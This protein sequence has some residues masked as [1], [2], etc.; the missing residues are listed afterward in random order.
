MNVR[1]RR[2]G[3]GL[4]VVAALVAAGLWL[5]RDLPRRQVERA[6]A[7]R[8]RGEVRVGRLQVNGLHQA[9][10]EGLKVRGSA[11]LPQL[12]SLTVARVEADGPL[13]EMARGRFERLRLDGLE[14]VLTPDPGRPEL[15]PA[16][17][18]VGLLEVPGASITLR[19]GD[20]TTTLALDAH[21]RDLGGAVSGEVR[22][23]GP[24]LDLA[25]LHA[26]AGAPG[27]LPGGMV[28]AGIDATATLEPGGRARLFAAAEAVTI[29]RGDRQVTLDRPSVEAHT[30]LVDGQVLVTVKPELSALGPTQVE[31]ALAL[32]PLR[33]EHL[34]ARASAIE[35]APWLPALPGGVTIAGIAELSVEGSPS[36]GIRTQVAIPRA[37]VHTPT[38]ALAAAVHLT[39]MFSLDG[40]SLRGPVEATI[41]L[42]SSTIG[43]PA[44]LLPARLTASGDATLGARSRFAGHLE[45]A[46]AAA[47]TTAADGTIDVADQVALDLAWRWQGGDVAKLVELATATG[48]LTLPAGFELDGKLAARGVVSGTL[49]APIIN[50]T[51]AVDQARAGPTDGD[52]GWSAIVLHAVLQLAWDPTTR[53]LE[54]SLPATAAAI[55]L[56]PLEPLE[57]QLSAEGSLDPAARLVRAGRIELEAPG[58][59]RAHATG[60]GGGA[61]PFSAQLHVDVPEVERVRDTLRPLFD[62]VPHDLALAGAAAADLAITLS[63]AE[64][65]TAAGPVTLRQAGFTST[66]GARIAEGLSGLLELQAAGTGSTVRA[67]A[68]G[69]AGGFQLL[70][71]TL[72]G[73]WSQT[74]F[75]LELE[76]DA[77]RPAVSSAWSGQAGATLSS[78]GGLRLQASVNHAPNR[79]H[80][81]SAE[82][83]ADDLAAVLDGSVRGPLAGSL[84]SLEGMTAT[85]SVAARLEGTLGPGA[86]S[87][88]GRVQIGAA[89][90]GGPGLEIRGLAAELPFD[91]SWSRPDPAAPLSLSGPRLVGSLRFTSAAAGGLSVPATVAGLV[92][93]ADRVTLDQSLAIPLL[94]GQ[95][96]LGEL[97]LADLM[98]PTRHLATSVELRGISLAESSRVLGLPPLEGSLDGAFPR[99]RLTPTTLHVDGIGQLALFGG[100]VEVSAI[101]GQ[102]VLGRYPRLLFDARVVDL[103]LA[104]L[105]Q[106]FDFGKVTGILAG[107]VSGCEL[108]R[109]VP[110]RFA[111]ELRTVGMPGVP[112]RISLKAVNNI[113]IVGTGSGISNLGSGL[114]RRF[115]SSYSYEAFGVSMVLEEDRFLLRGLEHRGDRELFLRGS[116]PLRLD[117]VNVDPGSTVSFRTMVDRLRNLDFSGV[118]TQP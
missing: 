32:H 80:A 68:T 59:G 103:D 71:G 10:V 93:E 115:I 14:V 57:L 67:R 78:P 31:L 22:I 113:A 89:D 19:A 30:A 72:F 18:E 5:A 36:A 95:V 8:F 6:L 69:D 43:W 117:V 73:D 1:L 64:G 105:T 97:A 65:W 35:L 114:L 23:A 37:T 21:L 50:A 83:A 79:P 45:V 55:H 63:A 101:S 82:L 62:P 74:R 48:A 94:G 24:R 81:W 15:G 76:L 41:E 33:L 20:D 56:P 44:L 75:G 106:T 53:D 98:R 46:T 29:R 90:L 84:P 112:Q 4:L 12:E 52:A 34:D 92:V 38:V 26:L 54:V 100:R 109:F 99:V 102:D 9:V 91:L 66:D 7:Q 88:R 27:E 108:F 118:Q 40:G 11:L 77:V 39:G 49:Q 104:Q 58:I 51:V 42:E 61:M 47:G 60:S 116:S 17:L 110:V 111:G 13:L 85:G 2:V 70:W 3:V 87:A 96:E 16:T 86:G 25:T 107:E 28:L